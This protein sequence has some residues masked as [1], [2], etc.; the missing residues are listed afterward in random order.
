[1]YRE[2]DPVC[3]PHMIFIAFVQQAQG[4]HQRRPL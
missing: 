3:L 1:M 2:Q 4:S